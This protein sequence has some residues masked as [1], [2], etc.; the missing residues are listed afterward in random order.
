MSY[1]Q[2][3]TEHQQPE[4]T[5]PSPPPETVT[6]PSKKSGCLFKLLMLF[7]LF[8]LLL[9]AASGWGYLWLESWADRPFGQPGSRKLKIVPGASSRAIGAMLQREGLIE[10]DRLFLGWLKLHNRIHQMQAGDYVIQSPVAPAHLIEILG[11]GSFERAVTIPEGWTA[12]QIARR[13]VAEKWIKSEQQWLDL[14]AR[15]LPPEA[16]GEAQPLGAE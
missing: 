11:K 2:F 8:C 15:P 6:A 9:L 7:F 4:A 10:N 13:L 12:R 3:M 14:I 1:C 5:P 16:L